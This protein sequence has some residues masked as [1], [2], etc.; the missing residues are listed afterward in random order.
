[1]KKITVLLMTILT[2][3]MVNAQE[4]GKDAQAIEQQVDAMFSSWNRHDYKD[5][6]KYITPDCDWV[7]IVGMWWKGSKEVQFAHQAFHSTIFKNT[8]LTKKQ[9]QVTLLTPDVALVHLLSHV[10]SFTTPTGLVMPEADD[11]ATL[12]YLK[13]NG[14]WLLRSGENVVVDPRA[15]ASNP[16][17]RMPH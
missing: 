9:V 7:N 15:H 16:V 5:M 4:K 10:G 2:G 8:T 17:L 11:L 13:S 14:N 6:N 3:L 1:M 12:V